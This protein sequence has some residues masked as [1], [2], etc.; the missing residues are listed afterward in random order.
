MD[1]DLEKHTIFKTLAGSRS[2]GTST[3]TSDT[4]Y[5]GIAIPPMEY[6]VGL[7]GFNQYVR[8]EP[9]DVTIFALRKFVDLA[10]KCNPNVIEQL[11]V[12]ERHIVKT[13]KWGEELREKRKLFLS[14][15]ALYTFTGYAMSQ[16]K[17]IKRHK[18]WLMSPPKGMPS[19]QD[20]GLPEHTLIPKDQLGAAMTL[21]QRHL[22]EHVPSLA[23][24]DNFGREQFWEGLATVLSLYAG[25]RGISFAETEDWPD[26]QEEVL[27]AVGRDLGFSADFLTLLA[28]EKS[29]STSKRE[30]KQYSDWVKNRN[31]ARAALEARYGY[32]CKHAMHLVRLMRMGREIL[33]DGELIVFRPDREELLEIRNGA[34]SYESL[35][36][37]AE[38]QD[39]ELKRIS[40]TSVLPK[41]PDEKAVQ[42]M[43]I[44]F[45]LEFNG[46]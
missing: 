20:Y 23:A 6:I 8:N 18:G 1:F 21:M 13:T 22:H 44:R 12:D 11:F 43:L 14:T 29:Y 24:A 28:K 4:D 27:L 42:E 3:P 10:L 30:W 26:V 38:G 37:W 35:I 7:R 39:K 17:R 36:E 33:E 9:D 45:S 25:T 32:D 46:Q 34:W 40:K 5:R 19:R 15:R 31:P 16:L 41:T 2:Y